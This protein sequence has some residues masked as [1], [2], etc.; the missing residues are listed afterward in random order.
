MVLAFLLLA[1]QQPIAADSGLRGTR[2]P[3]YAPDGRLV[4]SIDGDLYIQAPDGG[5]W[6][7]LT[8]GPAW[9]RE[10][11]WSR[12]GTSIVFSSNRAGSRSSW[13]AG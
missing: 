12:D 4:V 7:R 13:Q 8:T 3:A 9:D 11:T 1:L 2:D 10:P 5:A 6:T